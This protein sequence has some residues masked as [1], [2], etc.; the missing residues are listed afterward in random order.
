MAQEYTLSHL[1]AAG[2]LLAKGHRLL[3][4]RPASSAR[5]DSYCNF[6]F[7]HNSHIV[8]DRQEYFDGAGFV[9]AL[10]YFQA[11]SELKREIRKARQSLRM[12]QP[13][14]PE[15]GRREAA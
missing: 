2:Y 7:E 13:N 6:V 15:S 1:G 8:G 14:G 9:G 10:E 11:L 4:V 3:A 12:E 5:G